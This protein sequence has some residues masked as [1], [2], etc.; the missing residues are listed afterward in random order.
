MQMRKM[1]MLLCCF[2]LVFM[3][4]CSSGGGGTA[5]EPEPGNVSTG[6]EVEDAN[7]NEEAP[8]EE[9]EVTGTP[10]MDFDMGGRTL[11]W[12]SWYDESVKEDNPDSIEVK[13]KLGCSNGK[14]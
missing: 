9:E 12:V 7:K 6:T 4:A 10:E 14:T 3:V 1:G 13:K 11:K 8:V 2:L 5:S